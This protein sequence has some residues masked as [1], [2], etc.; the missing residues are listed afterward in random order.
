M[1]E[2]P[3][4]GFNFKNM[5]VSTSSPSLRND[6]LPACMAHPFARNLFE[7]SG[8]SNQ[9]CRRTTQSKVLLEKG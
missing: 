2:G 3:D 6:M 7:A 4:K 9:L 8:P 1:L 5:N